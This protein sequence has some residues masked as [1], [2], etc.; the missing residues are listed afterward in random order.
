MRRL[1]LLVALALAV[2]AFVAPAAMAS[3]EGAAPSAKAQAK[4]KPAKVILRGSDF[5]PMLWTAEKQAL[6]YFE[7][8]A[9]KGPTCYGS[10]AKAWPPLLSA[11]RPIAGGGLKQSLLGTVRRKGGAKQVTYD[12]KP[13]YAYDHEGR[14]EVL[15]HDIFLNGGWW[16]VLGADGERRP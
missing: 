3:G 9:G 1:L 7:P 16:Y 4:A 12:G 14:N 8:D 2:S 13:L 5:G 15:C 10:C 6:Y 11:G